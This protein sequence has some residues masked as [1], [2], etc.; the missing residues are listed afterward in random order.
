[1]READW[2]ADTVRQLHALAAE[3]TQDT[4]QYIDT[5]I[6][7][8]GAFQKEYKE[9]FEWPDKPPQ[10]HRVTNVAHKLKS[11]RSNPTDRLAPALQLCVSL[12]PRLVGFRLAAQMLNDLPDDSP[13]KPWVDLLQSEDF[14]VVS[15]P[16]RASCCSFGWQASG[17][18]TEIVC[19]L[20]EPGQEEEA[21]Q[22]VE[23]LSDL[24][25]KLLKDLAA[26]I[27]DEEEVT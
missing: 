15:S 9:T 14:Q 13:A 8:F 6:N 12:I 19:E 25:Y 20:G 1:M 23:Q 26:L 17:Q 5:A 7:R 3:S 18:F 10:S 22:I 11:Y 21:K 27:E 16:L 4:E 24:E 2:L